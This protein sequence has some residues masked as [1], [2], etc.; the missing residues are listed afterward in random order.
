M[1]VI[2]INNN[3]NL[4][5]YTALL[6]SPCL[7]LSAVGSGNG[8]RQQNY[9]RWFFRGT[10]GQN[11][12]PKGDYAQTDYN[13][14]KSGDYVK[15]YRSTLQGPV[16]L[17]PLPVPA[18]YNCFLPSAPQVINN[19]TQLWSYHYK[20]KLTYLR[21]LD[22]DKYV[23]AQKMYNPN[24]NNY[25][26]F[27][28]YYLGTLHGTV[29]IEFPNDLFFSI[30]SFKTTFRRPGSFDNIL[31]PSNKVKME[32]MSVDGNRASA[33]KYVYARKT[34][35][36]SEL[37]TSS[38]SPVMICE[39]GRSIRFQ[40]D[41][42][43]YDNIPGFML[44][45]YDECIADINNL[46]EWEELGDFA[47]SL[48]EQEVF[49][50]LEP[51]PDLINGE[52]PR[53][54]DNAFVNI[55]NYQDK[56]NGTPSD[57]DD[58]NIEQVVADYI[59][60]SDDENNPRA[61]EQIFI[62]ETD[63]EGNPLETS[64]LDVLNIGAM[65]FHIA[66][67]LGLGTID[68]NPVP[69]P[70][71]SYV[72][73]AEYYTE[74][75]LGDGLGS[76][77]VKHLY[78]SLPTS[79]TTERLPKPPDITEIVPGIL[80]SSNPEE[81]N[82]SNDGYTSD[83]RARF[84]TILVN[85]EEQE[86]PNPPFFASK[87]EFNRSEYT[88]PVFGGLEHK[89]D[90]DTDW[91]SPELANDP[92]YQ[93]LGDG[94]NE[95]I[96]LLF[97][98]GLT[99]RANQRILYIHKQQDSGT[100]HYL[101]YGI[102]IF[103]R[104]TRG[105]NICSIETQ[106]QATFLKPPININAFLIR[107]EF[108]LLLT[109][110][111]EQNRYAAITNNDKTLIRLIFDYHTEQELSVYKIDENYNN[112]TDT[113][114]V[115]NNVAD[116]DIF[117]DYYEIYADEVEIFFRNSVPENVSGKAINI[118]D[119][120]PLIATV[121]TDKYPL[122]SQGADQYLIPHLPVS[123][124]VNYIG[125]VLSIGGEQFIIESINSTNPNK[126]VINVY[127]KEISGTFTTGEIPDILDADY[128]Q[129]HQNTPDSLF[130]AIENMQTDSNWGL[131]NPHSLKVKIGMP[132]WE[133][134]REVYHT[135]VDGEDVRFLEKSRGIW[136]E[137][138]IEK[139]EEPEQIFNSDGELVDTIYVFRGLYKLTFVNF[140]LPQHEQYNANSVSVEWHKGI[141]RIK[142]QS[143]LPNGA[144]DLFEVIRMDDSG[145]NLVLYIND[146]SYSDTS[147]YDE[148]TEATQL[149][150]YYPGYKV[151][152]YANAANLTE[153]NI[154]PAQGEEV[155]Y[156]VFGLRSTNS[157]RYSK[158]S[159][160]TVMYAQEVIEPVSP[161]LPETAKYATRPDF[162]GRAS[163]TLTP[164]FNRKPNSILFYR[165]NDEAFLNALYKKSTVAEI[166][167]A[168]E[169]FGGNDEEFLSN[170]W[171]N[172]LNFGALSQSGQYATFPPDNGYAFPMPDNE[173][174][175]A[176]INKFI[177]W[178]NSEYNEN[179]S[180]ISQI[181]S[182]NQVL[183]PA[184]A[185]KHEKLS[186]IDFIKETIYNTFVPLTEMPVVYQH[187]KPNAFHP[188]PYKPQP[189]KQNIKDRDGY[190][191]KPSDPEFD[192]APMAAKDESNLSALKVIFTDFTLDGTSKNIY[193]YGVKEMNIQMKMS[194]FSDIIG[195]VKLVN[196]N[197]PEAPEIRVVIPILENRMLGITPSI[198]FEINAYPKNQYI[199]KITLYRALNMLDA[200]SIRSM[201]QVKEID[202]ELSDM[203]QDEKWIINDDFAD[204]TEIPYGTPLY[205]RLTVSRKVEYAESGSDVI[206]AEYAPSKPSKLLLTLIPDA[207]APD[208][209]VLSYTSGQLVD[210][211]LDDITLSWNKTV[212]NG[213]YHVY[214]MN[215]QGNWVQIKEIAG[216]N[217]EVIDL[218]L[219]DTSLES[220]ALQ[221]LDEDE[222]AIYHHFKAVAENSSGM[223]SSNEN[224]LTISGQ[225]D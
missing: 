131:N 217:D 143:A 15:I 222:Q 153:T 17:L 78:L 98:E 142:R 6:Q 108:P 189:K 117:P 174:F 72:Y 10:L 134:K 156:S 132:T 88:F 220:N 139:V 163:Y 214:K 157:E 171:K 37:L 183:I 27:V 60:L 225:S 50:R 159:A 96:P 118:L 119:S 87:E 113:E 8:N 2:D 1:S 138:N 93:H 179:V 127:K 180:S 54:N 62:G 215:A 63:D 12:L 147:E 64:L 205:Y 161:T 213:K 75:D 45:F 196:S 21:F 70:N 126:P 209:P 31:P 109:S 208:A 30:W 168:L 57:S 136:E 77:T 178:H 61:N 92:N 111:E 203:L 216:N 202:I 149:I 169:A 100:H 7:H 49:T 79:G 212:N 192:M 195:P 194:D 34:S 166:R 53:F 103:S 218:P 28:L 24:V 76:R 123:K 67:M 35:T 69:Y 198:Q 4:T 114:I 11:H 210:G 160:P 223:L 66:R 20:D 197:P 32:V 80:N 152:L 23:T 97:S 155:R 18:G 186:A 124:H 185:G 110:Q 146:S 19:L 104:S 94:C 206:I 164:I 91:Q 121:F 102:D 73:L 71:Q 65:D 191:L 190:L 162:F 175:I 39:N 38:P 130:V 207:S 33:D 81:H 41:T 167:E 140:Q 224:I 52:W 144:R 36:V 116:M 122:L 106:F 165:S 14:N 42:N 59:S 85:E 219:A 129:S 51:E 173:L 135:I 86:I 29:E 193:F 5:K 26:D 148:I 177:Q 125:G 44:Y 184:V 176:A 199:R 120:N 22:K 55:A 128:L 221:M 154:L 99:D 83:G 56:W 90:N 105:E 172:F 74:S 141:V 151:Y 200:Q 107:K 133:V 150:N 170:R 58:R 47:L 13:F 3:N 201:A 187:I 16:I 115:E 137:V 68:L 158:I 211:V 84:V 43:N 101:A 182:L 40:I 48:D 82:T 188:E 204:L 181:N 145:Q 89:M 25:K 46:G 95:T 9:L 112:L